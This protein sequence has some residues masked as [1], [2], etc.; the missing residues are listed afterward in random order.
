MAGLLWY[1][2]RRCLLSEWNSILHLTSHWPA[3]YVRVCTRRHHQKRIISTACRVMHEMCKFPIHFYPL[4]ATVSHF[5]ITVVMKGPS[6]L[7]QSSTTSPWGEDLAPYVWP[8]P[9]L[10]AA[11]TIALAV[12]VLYHSCRGKPNELTRTMWR[13]CAECMGTASWDVWDKFIETFCWERVYVMY[14]N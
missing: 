3:F 13:Y 10:A 4:C 11:A 14:I 7:M 5:F 1:P 6:Q 8:T 9:A 2:L 12:Y